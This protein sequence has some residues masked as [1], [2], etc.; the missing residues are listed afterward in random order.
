M[1]ENKILRFNMKELNGIVSIR[2]ALN[3]RIIRYVIS[4]SWVIRYRYTDTC[5]TIT[6]FNCDYYNGNYLKAFGG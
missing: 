6:S 4:D 2:L 1:E 5:K 3:T